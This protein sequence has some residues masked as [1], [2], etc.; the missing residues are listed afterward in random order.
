MLLQI[1]KISIWFFNIFF[2]ITLEI[3]IIV[4]INFAIFQRRKSFPG[5][6]LSLEKWTSRERAMLPLWICEIEFL[7]QFRQRV[8]TTENIYGTHVLYDL[9]TCSCIDENK[10]ELRQH[11]K[12][13]RIFASFL[14]VKTPKTILDIT[15]VI[16]QK[17]RQF[18]CAKVRYELLDYRWRLPLRVYLFTFKVLVT[19]I[20]MYK[21][22]LVSVTI[23]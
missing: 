13:W 16:F 10:R 23:L 18:Y 14:P 5:T 7:G 8:F 11:L 12:L 1:Q 22:A 3:S 21:T 9:W 17:E 2:K 15:V 4:T 20:I 19:L 6:W